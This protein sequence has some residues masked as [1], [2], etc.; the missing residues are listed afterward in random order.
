MYAHVWR[1]LQSSAALDLG[2]LLALALGVAIL[3]CTCCSRLADRLWY[4]LMSA[5]G[6]FL[7]MA[8]MEFVRQNQI[9]LTQALPSEPAVT[10]RAFARGVLDYLRHKL[11]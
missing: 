4:S 8:A 1:L 10:L 5:L 11:D 7:F 3:M 6:G 9:E 2:L